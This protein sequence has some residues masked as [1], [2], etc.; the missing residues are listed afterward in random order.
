MT[1]ASWPAD[2]MDSKDPMS[3]MFLGIGHPMALPNF[4]L[5]DG[6][7]YMDLDHDRAA[8]VTPAICMTKRRKT[9]AG[10]VASV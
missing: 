8:Q 6:V 3:L 2:D 1:G 4:V 5:S 9:D 10:G 7:G